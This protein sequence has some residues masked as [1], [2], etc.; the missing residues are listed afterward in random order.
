MVTSTSV[1]SGGLEPVGEVGLPVAT[2][3]PGGSGGLGSGGVI[4]GLGVTSS[5]GGGV[6]MT[7]VGG[8]LIRRLGPV[9][10]GI[11]ILKYEN[12]A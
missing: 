11:F 7:G 12:A 2:S 9:R 10:G 6:L 1:G 8:L 3:P 4:R 5:P